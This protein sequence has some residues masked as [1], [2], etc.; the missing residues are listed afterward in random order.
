MS[1]DATDGTGADDRHSPEGQQY[2]PAP[3]LVPTRALW[4]IAVAGLVIIVV[5]AV[6]GVLPGKDRDGETGSAAGSGTEATPADGGGS[7]TL[8]WDV[9]ELAPEWTIT[10]DD[11]DLWQAEHQGGCTLEAATREG[12]AS[13]DDLGASEADL[14]SYLDEQAGSGVQTVEPAGPVDVPGP[15]GS[16]GFASAYVGRAAPDGAEMIDVWYWRSVADEQT[17]MYAY[18]SCPS[19]DMRRDMIDATLGS[20]TV[21]G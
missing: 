15:E 11:A 14:A 8:R 13:G 9:P 21:A 2:R 1:D 20:L 12:D 7:S 5:L 18:L 4:L 19:G 3:R 6:A 16:L 17:S 10:T